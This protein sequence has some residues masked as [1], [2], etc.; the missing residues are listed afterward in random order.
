[1]S[2]ILWVQNLGN[3]FGPKMVF[4]D[5]LHYAWVVTD[6]EAKLGTPIRQ[7]AQSSFGRIGAMLY[8]VPSDRLRYT[9]V[10]LLHQ[11]EI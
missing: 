3:E 10:D 5:T 6:P 4:L 9:T 2:D 7:M 11:I 8:T 1:M